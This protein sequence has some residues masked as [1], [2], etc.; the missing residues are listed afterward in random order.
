MTW[1]WIDGFYVPPP[2][3][4]VVGFILRLLTDPGDDLTRVVLA[5]LFQDTG[6]LGADRVA[7]NLRLPGSWQVSGAVGRRH[8]GLSWWNVGTDGIACSGTVI[9]YLSRPKIPRCEKCGRK[10]AYST[11]CMLVVND[12]VWNCVGCRWA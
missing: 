11:S 9:A 4:E 12:K 10:P 6:L 8:V 3:R 5:D 7:A 1:K 2:G